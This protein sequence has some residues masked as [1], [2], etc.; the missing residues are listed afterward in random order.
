MT[1]PYYPEIFKEPNLGLWEPTQAMN[2]Q[3][4][5]RRPNQQILIGCS[6]KFVR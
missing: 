2:G 4:T 3:E 6:T 1:L 5:D